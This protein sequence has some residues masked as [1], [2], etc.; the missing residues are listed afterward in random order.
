MLQVH[1]TQIG[2][3]IFVLYIL[4]AG[5]QDYFIN[6]IMQIRRESPGISLL[7]QDNI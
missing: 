5:L 2:K 4:S 3:N 6:S 1:I 7:F